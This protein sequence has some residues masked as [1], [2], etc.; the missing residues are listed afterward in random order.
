MHIE[1]ERRIIEYESGSEY[2]KAKYLDLFV[3]FA[4]VGTAIIAVKKDHKIPSPEPTLTFTDLRPGRYG[5]N[6]ELTFKG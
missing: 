6:R 5:Q 4:V 2:N 3:H 1:N